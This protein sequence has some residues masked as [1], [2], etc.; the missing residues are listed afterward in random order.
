MSL[1]EYLKVWDE[2]IP[3]IKVID[4]D[5]ASDML[6]TFKKSTYIYQ[7][8]TP[9]C[10]RSPKQWAAINEVETKLI[11]ALSL[12]KSKYKRENKKMTVEEIEAIHG[13]ILEFLQHLPKF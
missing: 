3:K 9:A 11:T 5:N 13:M 12:A 10:L 8:C 6:A 4:E 1:G 2:F 7:A